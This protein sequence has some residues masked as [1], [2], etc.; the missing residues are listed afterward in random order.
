MTVYWIDYDK[1]AIMS[2]TY[3]VANL[4]AFY[5]EMDKIHPEGWF[6]NKEDVESEMCAYLMT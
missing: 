5:E 1:R 6:D 2:E 4:M 3:D